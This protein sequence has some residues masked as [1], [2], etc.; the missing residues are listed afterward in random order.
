MVIK[1]VYDFTLPTFILCKCK[2]YGAYTHINTLEMFY[3]QRW[4]IVY[5]FVRIRRKL[6]INF[7]SWSHSRKVSKME[8]FHTKSWI[9]S[10]CM[11]QL[12]FKLLYMY[13]WLCCVCVCIVEMHE[14][15][16]LISWSYH[17]AYHKYLIVGISIDFRVSYSTLNVHL[18]F[19]LYLISS[20]NRIVLQYAHNVLWKPVI[21]KA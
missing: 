6:Y 9:D 20:V 3:C 7:F 16:V 10:K 1:V 15:L 18:S 5:I 11:N 17:F 21:S 13:K 4:W 12:Y 8:H 2:L 19:V 14:F